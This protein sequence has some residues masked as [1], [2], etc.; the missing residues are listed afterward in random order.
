MTRRISSPVELV[1]VVSN[2]LR[3]GEP[4]EGTR[5]HPAGSGAGGSSRGESGVRLTLRVGPGLIMVVVDIHANNKL[6]FFLLRMNSLGFRQMYRL[7]CHQQQH[8]SPTVVF[9]RPGVAG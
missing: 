2:G 9:A 6:D 5:A 1:R 3:S 8:P 4:R 7:R